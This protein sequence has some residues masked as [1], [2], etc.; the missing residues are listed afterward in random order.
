MLKTITYQKED[1]RFKNKDDYDYVLVRIDYGLQSL[2]YGGDGVIVNLC[3][4]SDLW[5][6]VQE[7]EKRVEEEINRNKSLSVI[8]GEIY[9]MIGNYENGTCYQ[10]ITL[11]R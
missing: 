8:D 1:G 2:P 10:I 4:S 6:V 5:E 11:E 3:Q 7:K 9:T